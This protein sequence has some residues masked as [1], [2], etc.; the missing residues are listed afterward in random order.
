MAGRRIADLLI[1]IG[2][3]SYEF[4]QVTQK[5]E[6]D[7]EGLSK[8]LM[9]IGKTMSLA[10]TVPLMAI[11]A[12]AVSNADI[13][14]KAEAKVQQAIKATGGAAQLTFQQIAGYASELQGK[15]IFGD[16][17]ILND[18][19]AVLLGF[20]KIAG[21]NFKRTQQAALDLATV[22]QADLKSTTVQLGKA[23]N[24]PV[25]NLSALSRMGIQFSKEQTAVIRSLAET[26]QL[27][28]AQ[29]IIL[30]ELAMKYGGQ[31]EAASK[32]GLGA[33]Q[34]LK[35][36]WGDFLEQIGSLMMPVITKIAGALSQ[37]VAKLQNMNPHMLKV[38]TI[39][40]TL[41]A[42][43]GPLA[44]ALGS[45]IKILP[46]LKAG[47]LLL[48]SPI[49]LVKKAFLQLTVAISTNP[50][51]LLLTALAAGITLFA[52][53]GSSAEDAAESNG[54]LTNKIIDE[55][56]E[57]NLL[58]GKLSS[59][60]TSEKERKAALD[61]LKRVQPDI[62]SG[63]NS[64]S[65]EL[66][67]L[68][69]RAQAY[70]HQL[71][72]RIALARKQDQVA[73]AIEKQTEAG[74]KQ[75]EKEAQLYGYLADIGSKI[76]SGDFEF[77]KHNPNKGFTE[78]TRAS[79]QMKNNMV[80]HFNDIM[81]SGD[82]LDE[83]ARRVWLMFS[84]TQT[85]GSKIRMDG[86]SMR[87]I[88]KL[89]GQ[90]TEL[91]NDVVDAAAMVADAESDVKNFADAFSLALNPPPP[92]GGD[93]PVERT[94]KSIA[95]LNEEIRNLEQQKQESFDD[96]EI[97]ELNARIGELKKEVD[98]LNSL[99]ATGAAAVKGQITL[100]NDQIKELEKKKQ[101]AFDVAEIAEYNKQ[102]QELKDEVT[103]LN[104]V[105]PDDLKP[106]VPL[107]PI[108]TGD[109]ATLKPMVIP[110]R[111][112]PKLMG[113][114]SL[115]KKAEEMAAIRDKVKE[116]MFGWAGD[117]SAGLA[118]EMHE[119][120]SIV[121]TYVESLVQKGWSFTAALDEVSEK[122]SSAMKQ[123]D[124]QL[125]GFLANSVTAAAETIGQ[126][127]VGDLGLDGL[128][129]AILQSFANFLKQI[130]AQ[131]IEFGIMMIAFKSA[132]KS[133]LANPWAAIA[134]GAAMV[135]A[136]AIMTALIQKN[137]KKNVP[138][139][140][141]GGLAYG[142]TY[143]MVGDNPGAYVDPEVIAPLSKLRGM[144]TQ[145]GTQNIALALSG[146]LTAKGR[147]LVYVLGK[148]NFKLDVIG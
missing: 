31:A 73:A 110:M 143:A 11:G 136:A 146:E 69:E 18:N 71:V 10:V 19:A 46:T 121:G 30:D 131:L 94:R 125:S 28:E 14:E 12:V 41:T 122:V 48:L 112:E 102:I 119:V 88:Q 130:G 135:A 97:R 127:M 63:L 6:K 72:I 27:A 144:M 101:S 5:V 123:F 47:M 120:N 7:L 1:K 16:E 3:D 54:E 60:N 38:I 91:G 147:D 86:A 20:T 62:V 67:T 116:S 138:K 36:S 24:D 26:N 37:V 93:D 106:I 21:D 118:M 89:R 124:D 79:E 90:V 103:R 96:A 100:L 64:E 109:L 51:G 8:K 84:G 56:K 137:A 105:M 35:N 17:K 13:Q 49:A 107:E 29:G 39:V 61:E 40:A 132:L 43:T 133:V 113:L 55:G 128:L 9:S 57:V 45:V 92:P 15:S 76:T 95:E 70:N 114:E 81:A 75:A 33:L 32:V 80:S 44:L 140:A 66:K 141:K 104:S 98:R 74:V 59:A 129:T 77:G 108:L 83:K 4:K 139:L 117:I 85:G 34:Q 87:Q 126:M 111:I 2:A 134:V 22:L 65:L 68:T 148:E 82:S 58:I 50:I 23:L 42:A 145:G 53:F 52:A 78:W 142:P 115:N 99:G 25:K